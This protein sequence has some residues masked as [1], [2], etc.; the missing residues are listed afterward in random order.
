LK[1]T[2]QKPLDLTIVAL[3]LSA[4]TLLAAFAESGASKPAM[5]LKVDHATV[6]GSDLEP[7]RKAFASVGLPTDYGGPH[8]N[9]ITHMALLGFE[10]G[11]YLELIA[12]M[13][14]VYHAS[15]MMSGWDKLMSGNA[16]PCAWAIGTTEIHKEVARL[17]SAGIKTSGPEPGGRK[18]PD[19]TQI[20]WETAS[21]G[22][23]APGATLPFMIE[24]KTARN[25]R[26]QPSASL[27]NSG[28]TGVA[29]VIL[30]VKDLDSSVALFR[31]AY[32]WPQPQI[33]D[34]K[35]FSAK[36]AYFPGT[37]VM[38]AA[39]LD[40]TS[41]LAGRLDQFGDSPI[42]YLLG[43]SDFAAATKKFQLSSSS[44]WLG[45]DLAWFDQEKLLGIRIGVTEQL[46]G[47]K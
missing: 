35:D 20:G 10:D 38:L 4:L 3:S 37:P 28:L 5:I 9:G 16:G 25:L 47:G 29:L 26:V 7:I 44:R 17:K 34:R 15:G 45:R 42:A 36:I 12:P 46:K 11:S 40:K 23:G 8:A 43:A 21:V 27:K 24:D 1:R 14:S 22:D 6:C 31:K 39:P 33:E 30:G 32:G 19:G 41:W 13:K 18:K 2:C